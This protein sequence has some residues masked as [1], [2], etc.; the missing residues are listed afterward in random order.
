[1][2]IHVH[3]VQVFVIP[4]MSSSYGVVSMC[5]GFYTVAAKAS[6]AYVQ[7]A[8]PVIYVYLYSTYIV[9]PSLS[10]VCIVICCSLYTNQ[11]YQ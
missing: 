6:I 4:T 5:V 7:H 11:C 2:G 1:M 9:C 3:H 10:A 8:C